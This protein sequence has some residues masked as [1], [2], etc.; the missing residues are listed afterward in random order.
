MLISYLLFLVGLPFLSG[1]SFELNQIYDSPP[2]KTPM[3]DFQLPQ[4]IPQ[5]V[6]EHSGNVTAVLGKAALLNCRVRGIGNKTVSWMRHRDTHL[7][8]AGRYTYTNDQRFRAIHKVRSEDY[9]LQ[10]LPTKKSDAGQYECQISTTPVMSHLVYLTVAEPYTVILGGQ[11][12]FLEEGFTMNLTCLVRDSPE[13]PQYI[14]W[15]HNQQPISYSS[16]RGGISQIT[17]KGDTTA[18]FLLVQEARLTDSGSYACHASVGT[19]S[20]VMVHVIRSQKPEQ[21]VPSAPE[22][23]NFATSIHIVIPSFIILIIHILL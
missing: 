3:S 18:S 14:F 12:I 6:H 23:V 11:D 9:L 7:L 20:Q 19:I 4:P 22:P 8:T 10:I 21:L 16:E 13:P 15:Y 5:L 2:T 17:E 1:G